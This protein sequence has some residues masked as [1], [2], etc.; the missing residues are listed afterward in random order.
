MHNTSKLRSRGERLSRRRHWVVQAAAFSVAMLG[1]ALF[2]QSAQASVVTPLEEVFSDTLFGQVVSV[3]NGS[4]RCPT[5]S[6]GVNL[7]PSTSF[8]ACALAQAGTVPAG[9]YT[10]NNDYSMRQN[11]TDGRSDTFNNSSATF[12][13]PAGATIEYAALEWSGHTGE[14]K[15]SAGNTSAIRSCNIVGQQYAAQFPTALPP[16]PAAAT[17][18]AQS[19]GIQID[20]ASPVTV[21]PN[22]TRDSG[23]AWPN[24]SDRMYMGWSDVT[25][26]FEAA[27]LG[28]ST[29]VTVSNIWA[30]SGVNC[31][32]G[33]GLTLV[34]SFDEAVPGVVD[35]Q[36]K[37]SIYR[38]HIR[39]GAADAPSSVTFSGFE[40][41]S[42]TNRIG[43]VAYEGDRGT[44]GD[45]FSINGTDVTEP[46]GYGTVNDFFVSSAEGS[47]APAWAVNFSTDVNA[48]STNLIHVGDTEATLGFR[49][50]GDGYW[51]QSI[52][53]EAPVASVH[54][55]KTA[56]IAVGRPGDPVVW[57]ITVTNP[58]PAE[59]TD[60]VVSDPLE[61]SC[62]RTIPSSFLVS[63]SYTYTCTGVL[64]DASITNTAT[65]TAQTALGTPL[66]DTSSATVTVIHPALSVEKTADK[67]LYVDG[68][69]ITFTV[70]VRN[71]GDVPLTDVDL[72]DATTPGCS[73]AIGTLAP[74]EDRLITCTT[75][76]P[77]AGDQNTAVV[78]A[79]DPLGNALNET[80]TVL[81]PVARPSLDLSKTVS[82]PEA[83]VG[84]SVAFTV[85]VTNTGNVRIDDVDITDDRVTDCSA[86][87]GSLLPGESRETTCSFRGNAPQTFV[88]TAEATGIGMRC[89][90]S[91]P[92]QCNEQLDAP[93][94]VA[95]AEATVIFVSE[96]V[97]PPVDP[98]VNPPVDPPVT[99]P[100]PGG[101]A[102]GSGSGLAG[103]GLD[104]VPYLGAGIAFLVVGSAI[105]TI[106]RRRR[107][108]R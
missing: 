67:T 27:S 16:A 34:W 95:S 77:I 20:G 91:E 41:A 58:S 106:T 88:N 5:A 28:A 60:I 38:G 47:S 48:F 7:R 6:D 81:T 76:A 97:D 93:P 14:F 69:T 57:T 32:A 101:N 11:D 21:S 61:D 62:D 64:P 78:S 108:H 89:L 55:T 4:M 96:P 68:E 72:V 3:G 9:T 85:R 10:N 35:F 13:I 50:N 23:A 22:V 80:S 26:L 18:E 104:G 94:L 87:V 51:L 29:T 92:G 44:V 105:L 82:A 8:E 86:I 30:P 39:Q 40:A 71:A 49:T 33:W 65:V 46:T 73:A 84:Q 37:I 17:P 15:N 100:F 25:A 98:P 74:G 19:P 42:S 99:P 70:L 52:W 53:M 43:L 36:N 83:T 79:T 12:S 102:G 2:P 24:N 107:Q 66:S 75:T 31:A 59:I 103:T 54:I 45:R 63:N 56:D 1:V 90:G